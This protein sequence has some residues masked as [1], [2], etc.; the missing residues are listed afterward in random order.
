MNMI[1]NKRLDDMIILK[2]YKT[3]IYTRAK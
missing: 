1:L 2:E 3:Q